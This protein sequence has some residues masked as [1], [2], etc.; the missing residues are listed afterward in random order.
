MLVAWPL[1]RVRKLKLYCEP[2][3]ASAAKSE[4]LV[5]RVEERRGMELY[6]NIGAYDIM[7]DV[8]RINWCYNVNLLRYIPSAARRRVF[9]L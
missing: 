6:V 4:S 1:P 7:S 2:G 3:R 9:L 8:A 5:A